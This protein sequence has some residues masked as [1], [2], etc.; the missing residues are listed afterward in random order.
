MKKQTAK[1]IE[2]GVP[3]LGNIVYGG[4]LNGRSYLVTGGPGTGK[5]TLGLHFLSAKPKQEQ[6]LLISLGVTEKN[7]RDDAASI[8]VDLSNVITLDLSPTARGHGD[9]SYSLLEPWEAEAPNIRQRIEEIFPNGPPSRVFIDAF[10]QFR[11]LVPD[12]F[13]FRKQ[14]MELLEYLTN[15]GATLLFT[16]EQGSQADEDLQYLSDGIIELRRADKERTLQVTKFRGSAFAEG[17]HTMRLSSQ[18]MNIFERLVPDDHSQQF[19]AE[20]IPSGLP[21]LDSLSGGGVGRGTVTIISGPTGVGKT[22]L[23]AQFMRKAASRGERSVIFSFEESL[24][25]ISYRCEQIGIPLN[26]MIADGSLKVEAVEPQRYSPAEFAWRVRREV[27][28]LRATTVMIDSL[29]GYRQSVQGG[30]IVS[31][32]HALCRYLTNMGIT[33]LLVNEVATIAGGEMRVSEQGISY[34]ADAVYILRYVEMNGEIR[35]TIGMLK[36]RTGDFEKTLREFA[37]TGDGIKVGAPLH[38]MRGILQGSPEFI[39][40]NTVEGLSR[41][42]R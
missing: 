21:E 18:G 39:S 27:E 31:H 30:D 34:L 19:R 4:Y 5:T 41:G 24:A 40:E 3:G 20:S 23:G 37:I 2:T 14:V 29:A 35:K 15:E 17:C 26:E 22:T 16:S 7:L 10:S 32:V 42:L 12:T 38:G 28:E 25:T 11:H 1:R 9:Q 13:Q 33:V 8:E 36:K 6:A